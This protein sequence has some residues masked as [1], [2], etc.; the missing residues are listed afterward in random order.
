MSERVRAREREREREIQLSEIDVL[1]YILNYP[2]KPHLLLP[3]LNFVVVGSETIP[4]WGE[5]GAKLLRNEWESSGVLLSS[6]FNQKLKIKSKKKKKKKKSLLD[7]YFS[8]MCPLTSLGG[9]DVKEWS[10]L[11]C[12]AS[13]TSDMSSSFF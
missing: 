8:I 4:L 1:N 3:L 12:T 7:T 2:M 10:I 5:A 6:H 13:F 9:G 11:V